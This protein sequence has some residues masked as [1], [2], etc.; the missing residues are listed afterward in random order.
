MKLSPNASPFHFS[1]GA[2]GEAMACNFLVKKGYQIVEKN[3][4]CRLGEMDV[5]AKKGNRLSFIEIKSRSGHQFGEPQDAV[6]ARKQ[7]KLMKIA[8]WYLKEKKLGDT[9]V[10]FDVIAVMW[11]KSDIPEIRLIEHAFEMAG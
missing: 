9:P 4:R 6:D 2:R 5:I 1:L 8:S 7:A 11:K 10:S 3:Y